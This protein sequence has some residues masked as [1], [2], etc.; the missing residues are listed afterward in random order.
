MASFDFSTT[1]KPQESV[2]Q[3][4]PKTG[5]SELAVAVTVQ[6][7][8]SALG[9]TPDLHTFPLPLRMLAEQHGTGRKRETPLP[10]NLNKREKQA[11]FESPS[12]DARPIIHIISLSRVGVFHGFTSWK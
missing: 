5:N 3:A 4:S 2:L 12:R 11:A 8:G 9:R 1:G 10:P 6:H 7:R